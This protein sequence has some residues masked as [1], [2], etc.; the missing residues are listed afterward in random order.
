MA[1][2]VRMHPSYYHCLIS[3]KWEVMVEDKEHSAIIPCANKDEA[4]EGFRYILQ[5]CADEDGAN[6]L[7]Q[8]VGDGV[9]IKAKADTTVRLKEYSGAHIPSFRQAP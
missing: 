3:G 2:S 9:N 1:T 7:W 5:R 4:T 8:I 6:W